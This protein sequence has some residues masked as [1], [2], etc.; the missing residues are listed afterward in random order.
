MENG[1]TVSEGA[2]KEEATGGVSIP[3]ELEGSVTE[4]REV[5]VIKRMREK[6]G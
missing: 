1:Q 2:G 6:Q 5:S 3:V 4:T